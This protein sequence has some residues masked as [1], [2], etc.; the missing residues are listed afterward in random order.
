MLRFIIH[1][2]VITSILITELPIYARNISKAKK[3]QKRKIKI[4]NKINK[5]QENENIK[6]EI[7]NKENSVTLTDTKKE[8][9]NCN[10]KYN[11]C[12]DFICKNEDGIRSICDTSIDSFETVKRDGEKFRIGNDLFTFALGNCDETLKECPLAERNRIKNNYIA[13]IK[14]DLLTK[15]Y[16]DA[17]KAQSDETVKEVLDEYTTCMAQICG[18]KFSDCFT[19]KKIERRTDKCNS[20]LSKTSKPLSV[21]KMFYD[22]IFKERQKFCDNMG[23]KIDYDTKICKIPVVYGTP[24]IIE[25]EKDGKLMRTGRIKK[26]AAVKE[27]NYGEIVECT[28]EYFSTNNTY[29][30]FLREAIKDFAF[31]AV[32][33]VAGAAL[34]VAGAAMTIFSFGGAAAQGVP[35]IMN[36]GSLQCKAVGG[37]LGGAA[38]FNTDVKEGACFIKGEMIATMNQYFKVL[39]N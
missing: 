22:K 18:F 34:M 9:L 1:S 11:I 38:K 23:G 24:E 17:M 12:M 5:K 13:Q 21:K 3:S 26:Q 37:A 33:S 14:D 28:Q 27:F 29:K 10:E 7:K 2:I 19:I 25:I 31:A 35:M 36:G 4:I 32:R 8:K 15:N 6:T 16:L 30:P 39:M 20:V